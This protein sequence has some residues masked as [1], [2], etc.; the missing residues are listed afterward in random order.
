M[1]SIESLT[2]ELRGPILVLGASGFVGANLLRS[3]LAVRSDVFGT[4]SRDPAWR[5]ADCGEDHVI[6]VDLLA[7]G[8]VTA[9]LDRVQ[10]A[11]VFDC[12]AYGAYSFEQDVERMFHTNVVLKQEL[13][14]QLVKRGTHC[15]IHAGSSSEYGARSAAPDEDVALTP[16][17]HYAVTKS[18]A[19][20][21]L[22][23]CGQHRGLRCANLR[24]Y[25]VYGPLEDR[26]RLMPTLV[27]SV[28]EGKLPPFVDPDTSRDFVYVDDVTRAFLCAAV[29]LRPDQ[30]GRSFNIGSGHKT[31]I[32]DLAYLA[33]SQFRIEA[34]P[35]FSTM[36]NR[37]WDVN[38]W[39]ANPARAGAVLNWRPSVALEEGL[40]LTAR[41]YDSLDDVQLYERA[42]KKRALDRIYSVSAVIACYKDAQAIPIMAER[43]ERMFT[44][45]GIDYEIIFVNDGSPDDSEE[46]IRRLSA[47][48]PHVVGITHSRNFGSQAAF[49]SGMD[50][51][52][53]NAVVLM[54]GD[55]QDPP[56]LIP[57]FVA[58]WREGFDVVYGVRVKREAAWYMQIAY[59]AFYRVFDYF[60]SVPIPRD[61]GDFSLIDRRVV[62][63][64]LTCQERDLFMRGLRAYVGFR[65]TGVPYTRPERM[66]G[67]STNS[68][69][70]NFGW[71]KKG[72]LSFSRTPLDLLTFSG[73]SLVL[74]SLVLG[75]AQLLGRL[76]FP[77]LAPRGLTTVILLI[78]FFGSFTIFAIS[79]VGE[80][81]AKI[82]EEVKAR[83]TYIRRHLTRGGEIRK[84]G[85][86]G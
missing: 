11:T 10:P 2:R 62:K 32:R 75:L 19:A 81:I 47:T 67:R 79:L 46:V 66:F 48:N 22:Y 20:N 8:N 16:N 74:L 57:E 37:A 53:K 45:L 14:E 69:L 63:W 70:K 40:A 72:I 6:T 7:R 34:E 38:D 42:S 84:A 1:S 64:L 26:S 56:E 18:A 55:L 33:K 77:G 36:A 78:I 76:F 25:S 3:L 58:K 9:L 65:Q 41:W 54:D 85:G 17:S 68:M 24:L 44:T 60:S 30:Y 50:L 12:V 49:R 13:V 35:Q 5:L 29:E 15:Y 4:A 23:F 43:L 51:A 28:A 83:P 59:K 82:F 86:G 27:A 80:Y 61:A 39:Y 73:I 31:T 71:A 52:S 21:L